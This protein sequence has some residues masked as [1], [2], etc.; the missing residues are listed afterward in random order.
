[1]KKLGFIFLVLPLLLAG[2]SSDVDHYEYYN[3]KIKQLRNLPIADAEALFVAGDGKTRAGGD[4]GGDLYK[5]TYNGET[6]R[7][8]LKTETGE[9]LNAQ[10]VCV[11]D[12]SEKYVYVQI[13]FHEYQD[14]WI[15]YCYEL[16]VRKTDGAIY[17]CPN[18]YFG[19]PYISYRD[20]VCYVSQANLFKHIR[21][22][23][24]RNQDIFIGWNHVKLFQY[25]QNDAAGNVYYRDIKISDNNRGETQI[26][27]L[28]SGHLDYDDGVVNPNGDILFYKEKVCRL[29]NGQYRTV[30]NNISGYNQEYIFV[31]PSDPNSFY[32]I[33]FT[34]QH[35]E[36]DEY[37]WQYSRTYN[38]YKYTTAD[39]EMEG[40]LVRQITMSDAW[41]MYLKHIYH[42]KAGVVAILQDA[43]KTLFANIRSEEDILVVETDVV[44]YD[45]SDN[46]SIIP[47]DNYLYLRNENRISRIDPLTG[48]EKEIFKDSGYKVIDYY[49]SADN[50]VIV[51]TLELTSGN[52]VLMEVSA[53]GSITNL[54]TY[55]GHRVF[56]LVRIR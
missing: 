16:I 39:S 32:W 36:P 28:F 7:V 9:V 33:D 49:V 47:S 18:N 23:H 6:E 56:Q 44:P 54:E 31:L 26:E 10:T 2:C 34:D 46:I 48:T 3:N 40:R 11:I 20:G 55:D 42:L 12:L 38:L 27:S 22:L 25:I 13:A 4:E 50:S 29:N 45:Y 14:G 21:E 53:D 8:E 52:E 35:S 24:W 43:N 51:L 5:I 41:D 17:M 30:T 37:D 15:A 1:M 19:C